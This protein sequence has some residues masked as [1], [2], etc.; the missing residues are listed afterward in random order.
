MKVP[1][2]ES[3]KKYQ[4]IGLGLSLSY[5]VVVGIYI[6]NSQHD[7][8]ELEPNEL[9]DFIAGILG[10]VGILWLIL[11]FWQQGDELRSSVRA[12]ELQSE[13]L[14]NSVEQQK[15]L[16]EITRKQAEAEISALHEEREA[17]QRASSP[18]L[19]LSCSGGASISPS[20]YSSSMELR[21]IGADCSNVQILE[22]LEGGFPSF[23]KTIPALP[24]GDCVKFEI[25]HGETDHL[26]FELKIKF[27]KIN[28]E[29]GEDR[30]W[31]SRSKPT[32]VGFTIESMDE[33]QA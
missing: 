30:F 28:N 10:P 20:R 19:V 29:I 8:L 15:A 2:N 21:N 26:G 22:I 7:L 31:L 3:S 25:R 33:E 11:G 6:N 24:Y 32:A 27:R 1:K 16:V 17:R 13:E 9:G 12:L 14:R 23:L 18:K 4:I 5:F